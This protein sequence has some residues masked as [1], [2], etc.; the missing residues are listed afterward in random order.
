MKISLCMIV[1]NEEKHLD[2]CLTQI[3]GHVDEIVIV[4][5]GSID[6]T[7]EIAKKYTEKIYD[8]VWCDDFAKARNFSISKAGNDWILVLDADEF[9][10]KFNCSKINEF[11]N[12]NLQSVGRIKIINYF[13]DKG[14]PKRSIE[15]ISRLFNRNHFFY[16]GMIH[17]QLT[18]IDGSRYSTEIVEIEADHIGYSDQLIVE[19]NKME[20]NI[21]LL[22][23]A[24]DISPKEAYFYYQIAKSYFKSKD[25]DNAYVNFKKAIELCTNIKYEYAENLIQSYGYTLLECGRY[26]EA[27]NLA[28]YQNY[29][30]NS[31]DFNFVMGLI[32]MNNAEFDKSA[33]SFTKC[34]GSKEGKVE[35]IN[36]YLPNYNLGVI[37]ETLNY[38]G[39]ALKYYKRCGNYPLALERLEKM[40]KNLDSNEINKLKDSIKQLI[41]N[42]DFENAKHL[43]AKLEESLPS[44][45]E[46][47]T[48]KAIVFIIEN[49]LDKAE[50]ILKEGLDIEPESFDLLYN[51]GYLYQIKQNKSLSAAYYNK[52]IKL[53]PTENDRKDVEQNL[54]E[55]GADVGSSVYE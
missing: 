18:K 3:K 45:I 48:M 41:D 13:E 9:V 23:K 35:G 24:I 34:I 47:Y 14:E 29:Y 5:T 7:K 21:N 46:L 30:E 44:D 53:A 2:K 15:Y 17:E 1:K 8:F 33:N 54:L 20:R 39:E 28:Q 38:Y 37:Y 16:N 36:S 11:T 50:T 10:S 43:I 25:Y 4:D 52:A 32:Y 27:M 51:L 55:L 26:T 19:K 31:P 40:A 6:M 42:R 22:K 49:Q 12:F